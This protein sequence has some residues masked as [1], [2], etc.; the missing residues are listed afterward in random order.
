LPSGAST[1]AKQPALGT[2]GTASADV[3]TI[4]GVASMTPVLVNGSGVTQP[5][6]GTV[7]VSSIAAGDNNIGNVDVVTLPALAAGTNNIGDVD[8][9]TL[10]AGTVAGSSSLPA[11]TN[12]IGDVDVLT[13]PG[14]AGTAAHNAAT[15]GN[16]VLV[17]GSASAAA[18][19]DVGAD[20]RAVNAWRLR[21]GAAAAVLTA[22]G[23]L[24]G[25]DAANG[26]D[27]DVT[28]LPAL[29]AGTNNIGDVDVLTVPAPLSTTGGGTEAT[30]LRVTI[31]TDSTGVVSVDDN[32]GSL[33]VDGTVTAGGAAAHGAA[34]SGNPLLLGAEARTT[35]PTAVTDGQAVRLQADKAGRL[36]VEP[37]SVRDLVDQGRITL[38]DTTETTLL[39]Q[40]A[41]TFLD[42]TL[43]VMSNTSATGVRVDIRDTT[44]GTVRHSQYL[45]A[46]GGGAVIAFTVP[47]KQTTV[48]L[49]WT[50]QLSGS[51]TDVRITAQ[52]VR[53]T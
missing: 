31:A 38:T 25:G 48:N 53:R 8:V 15:S 33:T 41:S 23:A 43:L 12:N 2:A 7:A 52:A 20:G 19:A 35:M 5:V 21:N 39:A 32:G 29:A 30:A 34:V 37:H 3:I 1:A 40:V 9:L 45:A 46:N 28:R 17:A 13:L 24:I 22:A 51:V 16:P 11:G 14:V 26:L 49:N 27:V 6:S 18:P 10:P 47:F 42:L 36:V 4:Q 50:A 44:G